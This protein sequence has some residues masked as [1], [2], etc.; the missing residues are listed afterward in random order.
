[1][2][3]EF[4]IEFAGDKIKYDYFAIKAVSRMDDGSDTGEIYE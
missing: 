2:K 3:P 1:M 4:E